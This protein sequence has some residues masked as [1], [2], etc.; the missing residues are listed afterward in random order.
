ML[1]PGSRVE[2]VV[3]VE[4]T[5]FVVHEHRLRDVCLLPGSAFF[6]V[7]WRMLEARGLDPARAVLSN[8]LFSEPVTTAAG[9]G[10]EVRV[11]VEADEYGRVGV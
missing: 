2:A 6:D 5:D 3:A 8:V 4:P 7:V 11:V 10:R 1:S 9:I